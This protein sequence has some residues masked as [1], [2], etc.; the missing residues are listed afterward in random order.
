MYGEKQ[1][2]VVKVTQVYP[3]RVAVELDDGRIKLV[4]LILLD[5][6]IYASRESI[7]EKVESSFCGAEP[8]MIIIGER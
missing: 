6:G 1:C 3:N 7:R 4:D 8:D 5:D 2:N